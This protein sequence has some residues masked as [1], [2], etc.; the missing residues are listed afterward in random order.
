[1][2][3]ITA[4]VVTVIFIILFFFFKS[5]VDRRLPENAGP[6]TAITSYTM[7]KLS[8]VALLG[9]IPLL[10]LLFFNE[11]PSDYG[12]L[13]G[14]SCDYWYLF[15][16]FPI[17]IAVINSF[18]SRNKESLTQYPDLKLKNWT[19]GRIA[20]LSFGWLLYLAA[21]EFLFRGFLFFSCCNAYGFSIALMINTVVYSLAHIP[22]GKKE[23]IGAIPF[24]VLLCWLAWLTGSVWLPFVIHASLALSTQYFS[25]YRQ[26]E[27]SF[28]WRKINRQIP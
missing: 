18:A 13:A 6:L 2:P 25:I 4:I 16:G 22:K 9:I 24:G 21:Y 11:H 1:M 19:P 10:I 17:V 14:K 26:A 27:M 7:V 8:G 12:L 28:S 5:L 23:T 3:A 20:V 15:I